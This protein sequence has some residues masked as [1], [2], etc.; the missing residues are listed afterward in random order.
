MDPLFL[1]ATAFLLGV[2]SWVYVIVRG[3]ERIDPRAHSAAIDDFGR[4]HPAGRI[5][6]LAPFAAAALTVFGLVGYGM[7]RWSSLGVMQSMLVAA[8]AAVVGGGLLASLMGHWARQAAHLDVPDQ[9]FVLQGHV[10]RV[11]AAATSDGTGRVEY[12]VNGRH[13]TANARTIDDTELRMDAEV[14][15]NHLED[16]VVYVEAWS[17]VEERL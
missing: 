14:V 4:E 9:R 10:A 16:G 5:V 1:F 11:V 17:S 7:A 8:L 15:I 3:V 12:E 13:V 6:L 2:A